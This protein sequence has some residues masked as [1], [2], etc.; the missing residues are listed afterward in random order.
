MKITA[1]ILRHSHVHKKWRGFGQIGG[2]LD[3][4]YFQLIGHEYVALNVP[5]DTLTALQLNPMVRVDFATTPV[6]AVSSVPPDD[7]DDAK[8]RE[9]Q[10]PPAYMHR[11]PRRDQYQR[12]K[13][14]R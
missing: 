3:G 10:M 4:A 2:T 5:P 6:G 8:P 1:T 9:L 7:I 13:G 11:D 12:A 14:K